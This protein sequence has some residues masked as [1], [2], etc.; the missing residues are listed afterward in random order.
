MMTAPDWVVGLRCRARITLSDGTVDRG[1][2][3]YATVA[4]DA[5][6]AVFAR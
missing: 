1:T 4:P 5:P 3:I 6:A 2:R